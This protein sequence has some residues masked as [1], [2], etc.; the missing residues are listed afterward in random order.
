MKRLFSIFSKAEARQDSSCLLMPMEFP[1]A[2]PS[3]AKRITVEVLMDD[4][5]DRFGSSA[6]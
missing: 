4:Q 1:S 2:L 5:R 6:P 3:R